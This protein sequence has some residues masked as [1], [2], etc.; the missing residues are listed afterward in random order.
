[1]R[2]RIAPNHDQSGNSLAEKWKSAVRGTVTFALALAFCVSL[3]PDVAQAIP[4][5]EPACKFYWQP[6][7]GVACG[8]HELDLKISSRVRTEFWDAFMGQTD[9]FVGIRSRIGMRYNY[10]EAVVLFG[11]FQDARVYEIGPFPSGAGALYRRFGGSSTPTK[12][13]SSRMRQYWAEIRPIEGLSLRGGRQDIKLGTQAMYKEGNWKYLKVKRASQRLVGTVGWTNVERSNDAA[14]ISYDWNGYNFY[15]FAGKPTTGVFDHVTA[16]R[17]QSD[18]VYGGLS[19]TA[20]RGTW[21]ENTEIR[22]FFLGYNDDRPIRD[23][24]LPKEVEVYTLGVSAIGIYPLGPG[25]LDVL[26]WGAGQAGAYNGATH[27]AYA[28]ILEAGY[29]LT[30]VWSKPWLRFGVNFASGDSGNNTNRHNTFFNMLPT[31][32]LY[33]GFADTLAFQN[34]VDIVVQLMFKP[35]DMLSVNVMFHQFYMAKSAD[36]QYFGT[37]AFNKKIFG[38]GANATG[39]NNN[40]GQEIDVIANLK[41]HKHLSVQGGYSH[42][43]G[44]DVIRFIRNETGRSKK[45]LDFGYIQVAVN[46]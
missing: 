40:F 46:Y 7:L 29:Q 11:E 33:Y 3:I 13:K 9:T 18:I 37:G 22:P 35:H 17:S 39:G 16:Y 25:N 42:L 20:K 31:N 2:Y 27:L 43:W 36:A 4:P 45:D 34:L 19:V 32:H 38:Y 15:G 8:K 12:A 23:G 24:G 5:E 28:A 44:S 14:V 1:M 21:F 10:D 26:L 30:D 6:N 41:L